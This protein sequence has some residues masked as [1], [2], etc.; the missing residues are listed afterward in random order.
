VCQIPE[1]FYRA[2]N[3]LVQLV[4]MAR[5]KAWDPGDI[6]PIEDIERIMKYSKVLLSAISAWE[7]IY[8][9]E[10]KAA[11]GPATFKHA[12]EKSSELHMER[13]KVWQCGTAAIPM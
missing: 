5:R 1:N 7:A 4:N 13:L 10:V 6:P 11:G 8:K 12:R 2:A 3:C 9:K